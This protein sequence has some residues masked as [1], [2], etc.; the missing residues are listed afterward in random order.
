MPNRL[1]VIPLLFLP[2]ACAPE[3]L[4]DEA[5]SEAVELGTLAAGGVR[6]TVVAEADASVTG[7]TPTTS[8]GRETT[9][10]S[11]GD[12]TRAAYL[13]FAV[14]ALAGSVRSATLRLF[15]SNPTWNGPDV[16]VTSS[17]WSEST[18]TY[19]TRP[20]PVGAA[21]RDLS[22]VVAG[23]WIE[24]D[25][26]SAVDAGGPV[27]F[28]L[29]AD[30][31]DR[32][33][34]ASREAAT[35]RPEL[36]I[37][38]DAPSSAGC[39]TFAS[40]VSLGRR[41]SRDLN[42]ASGLQASV[43]NDGVLWAHDDSGDSHRAF[44]LTEA[45]KHLGIYDVAGAGF[46]DWEG[47]GIGRIDGQWRLFFG[48]IG[49]NTPR[50]TVQ[51]YTVPEPTVSA[52]QAPV[53]ATLRGTVR[54]DLVY[55]D[56]PHNAE[57]IFV[58]PVDDSVYVVTKHGYGYTQVFR[59]AAPH[60]AGTS[61]LEEVAILEFDEAPLRSGDGTG[62]LL[63]TAADISS[64]GDEIIIK[65]YASTFLWRRAP[66]MSIADALATE[67]CAVTT[68]DGETVA[69]TADGGGYIMTTESTGADLYFAE[70]R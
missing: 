34:V 12:P 14:P 18:L 35:G 51:V 47:M 5:E 23:A 17:S 32:I 1:A 8:A 6:T 69:F 3:D 40:R 37:D 20:A 66:G 64:A 61:T 30:S 50:A 53:T 19:A 59:K 58:D 42:E 62:G 44:A 38:S 52:T 68:S 57:G 9:L 48:D 54:M 31:N 39:P 2:L 4:A 21:L 65:T 33:E 22:A 70:R 25:V 16:H 36:V 13:R 46:Q 56:G 63:A 28:V 11:D 24:I 43:I 29:L 55:P 60:V 45:G 10:G 15:V 41:E 67:P 7:A 27:S 49:G 26:T